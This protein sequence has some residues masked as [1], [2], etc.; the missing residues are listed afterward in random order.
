MWAVMNTCDTRA[1]HKPSCLGFSCAH[2]IF[3]ISFHPLPPSNHSP[4]SPHPRLLY[5]IYYYFSALPHHKIAFVAV[6]YRKKNVS[7]TRHHA[8]AVCT[9]YII[10]CEYVLMYIN[11]M[12][13]HYYNLYVAAG[14]SRMLMYIYIYIIY[15]N[16]YR[17]NHENSVTTY[18]VVGIIL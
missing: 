12:W 8:P 6:Y 4:F 15:H 17:S 7:Y 14:F 13:C 18:H 1:I 11:K 16:I 5:C 3:P 10:I 9:L 2:Y